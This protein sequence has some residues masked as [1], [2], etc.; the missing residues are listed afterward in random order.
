ME[1]D[2]LYRTKDQQIAILL[3]ASGQ[4]LESTDWL[5]GVCFF[6][7]QDFTECKEVMTNHYKGEL[8]VN[9]KAFIDA[10]NTIKGILFS[11]R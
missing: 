7:F 5:N 3:Y 6:L 9:S 8:N 4:T 2:K 10:F 1:S 11:N